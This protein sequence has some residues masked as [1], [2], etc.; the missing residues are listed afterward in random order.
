MGRYFLCPFF[1]LVKYFPATG[2]ILD[3]GCGYGILAHLLKEDPANAGRRLT[4]IDHDPGKIKIA[5]NLEDMNVKFAREN[6]EEIPETSFDMIS[7]IDV[8][9]T[10][11]LCEWKAMLDNCFKVL[12]PG[13]KLIIKDVINEPRWKY[14]ITMLEEKLAIEVLKITRGGKPHIESKEVYRSALEKSD[15]TISLSKSIA[16]WSWLGHYVIVA[17]KGKACSATI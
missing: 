5:M 11:D 12:R 3:V 9:Y 17:H 16:T 14:W 7:I 2:D 13:G 15:F 4:G 6:L 1:E 10:V 8:L